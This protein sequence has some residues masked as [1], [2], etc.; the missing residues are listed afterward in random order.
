[1]IQNKE[2]RVLIIFVA[3]VFECGFPLFLLF[4]FFWLVRM[5]PVA[6]VG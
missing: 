5:V 3:F 4:T 1:M 6:T 2:F